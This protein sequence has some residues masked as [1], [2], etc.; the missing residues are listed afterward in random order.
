M[1]SDM[2]EILAIINDWC[3]TAAI[4]IP[5]TPSLQRR[6]HKKTCVEQTKNPATPQLA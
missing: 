1:D 6:A 2:E 4:I 3:E 5:T